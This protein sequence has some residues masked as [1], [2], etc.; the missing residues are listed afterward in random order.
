MRTSPSQAWI[1]KARPA[2]LRLER[3]GKCQLDPVTLSRYEFWILRLATVIK[4]L[5]RTLE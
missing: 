2:A 1:G 5:V 4:W 3:R